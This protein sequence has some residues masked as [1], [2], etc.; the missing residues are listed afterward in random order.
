MRQLAILLI[1]LVSAPASA[2]MPV[3]QIKIANHVL[4]TEVAHTQTSRTQGLMYRQ[5]MGGNRGM[6]FVFPETGYHSMWMVNTNIPLS[7]AFVDEKGVILNIADMVPHTRTAHGA[8]GAAKYAIEANLGWFWERGIKAGNY[9]DGLR[10][11]P[12]AE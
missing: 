2:E 8:A 3:I 6:L 12:A 7:V 4:S 5:S 9:V 11:A 10:K 1:L